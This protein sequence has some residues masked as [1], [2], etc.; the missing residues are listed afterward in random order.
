MTE[1]FNM[2]AATVS[3]WSGGSRRWLTVYA[4]CFGGESV[5]GDVAEDILTDDEGNSYQVA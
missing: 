2:I 1:T 3:A 5:W 4:I